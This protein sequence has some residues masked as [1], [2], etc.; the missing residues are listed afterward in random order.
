[1]YTI[2]KGQIQSLEKT[3][4]LE[5]FTDIHLYSTNDPARHG[6]KGQ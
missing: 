6:L 4:A 3:T 2:I 5:Q 1:M